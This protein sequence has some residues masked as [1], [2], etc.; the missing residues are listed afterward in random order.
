M[1]FQPV[2]H[3][4]GP[5]AEPKD[6][7][8]EK[9]DSITEILNVVADGV[10]LLIEHEMGEDEDEDKET[11]EKKPVP[12]VEKKLVPDKEK[13]PDVH[14]KPPEKAP[15][16]IPEPKLGDKLAPAAPKDEGVVTRA[17]AVFDA[18]TTLIAAAYEDV[19]S[20]ISANLDKSWK[21]DADKVADELENLHAIVITL[22]PKA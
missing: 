19:T 16:K 11:P 15:E 5:E 21:D 8:L 2:E 3:A 12:P 10:S 22:S 20:L 17:N 4:E 1:S 6:P 9:L 7:V 14:E 13:E 18:T